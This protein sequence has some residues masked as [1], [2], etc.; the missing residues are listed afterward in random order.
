MATDDYNY[1]VFDIAREQPAFDRFTRHLGAG[2]R[3][4]DAQLED[5]A[6]GEPVWLKPLWR[7][8]AILEFGS[9]T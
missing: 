2:D 5:L 3:A 6:T 4:P 7:R 8:F 1:A 9:F